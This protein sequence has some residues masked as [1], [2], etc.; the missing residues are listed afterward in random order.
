M[1]P[2]STPIVLAVAMRVVA[3]CDIPGVGTSRRNA[4]G[5]QK[6]DSTQRSLLDFEPVSPPVNAAQVRRAHVW[7]ICPQVKASDAEDVAHSRRAR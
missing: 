3:F 4:D 1:A 2:M 5:R 6:D 7:L